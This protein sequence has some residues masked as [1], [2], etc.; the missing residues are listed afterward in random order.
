MDGFLDGLDDSDFA[1]APRT[2]KKQ[3][4]I[5][6]PCEVCGGRGEVKKEYGYSEF[7][8]RVYVNK[9]KACNGR[10]HFFASAD[11]R[12]KR[13]ASATASK[14]RKLDAK[15]EAFEAAHPGLIAFLADAASWSGFA[16][17]LT[18]GALQYG[19]LTEGQ[20]IAADKMRTKC[21]ANAAQREIEKKA[22]RVSVD[23][24]AIRTMFDAA[25]AS[26]KAKPVYRADGL[27]ISKAPDHGRNAGALYVKSGHEYAGKIIGAEF[28]PVRDTP[29]DVAARLISIAADPE[30]AAIKYGQETGS[31]SCCGR[32]L[33]RKDSIAAGIG[34]ICATK[35][36]F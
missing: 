9:C 6:Y 20:Q 12:A 13:R 32:K 36:G 29:A 2:A 10:G 28:E 4:R 3:E 35:W 27:T 16:A 30:A 11:V 18:A 19:G 14:G 7:T 33:T 8:R 23:L 21:E 22:S 1:N 24:A 26:G 31:C 25:I 15:R 17:S 34:P 5:Q